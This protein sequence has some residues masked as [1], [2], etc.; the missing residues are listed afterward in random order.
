MKEKK[1][2]KYWQIALAPL[3]PL[4]VIGGYF[5][6]YLG[7]IAILML[8]FMAVLSLFRGRYYCGWFC[9]MGAFF[10]RG[11]SVVSSKREMLPLFKAS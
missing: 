7:Y 11:L 3:V 1:N 10:E 9:A 2:R 8:V 6:P 4:V 5:W